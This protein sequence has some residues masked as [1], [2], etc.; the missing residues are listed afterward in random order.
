M[1]IENPIEKSKTY[2]RSLRAAAARRRKGPTAAGSSGG[3][4]GMGGIG[5]GLHLDLGKFLKD[6]TKP[7]SS[8]SPFGGFLDR[9]EGG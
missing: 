8:S 1:D 6:H 4:R 3:N 7:N 9:V 2:F 5:L